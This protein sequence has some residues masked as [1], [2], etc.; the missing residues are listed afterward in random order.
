MKTNLFDTTILIPGVNFDLLMRLTNDIAADVF[1][2]SL[3]TGTGN[4]KDSINYKLEYIK[5]NIK[6]LA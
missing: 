5:R 3:E 4:I 2:E 1:Q 6:V